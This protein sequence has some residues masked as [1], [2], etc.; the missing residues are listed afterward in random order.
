LLSDSVISCVNL[1][2]IHGGRIDRTIGRLP[3]SVMTQ[4]DACLK[5]ALELP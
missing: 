5:A 1:A 3:L 4:V 2:T